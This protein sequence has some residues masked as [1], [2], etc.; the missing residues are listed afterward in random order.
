MPFAPFSTAGKS[1]VS[2]TSDLSDI[3]SGIP[4]AVREALKESAEKMAEGARSRVPVDTGELRDS[5]EVV[6]YNEPG[7]VGY[8]VVAGATADQLRATKWDRKTGTRTYTGGMREG[9]PY[10]HWV[11]Y[12]SVHNVPAHPF[13][14]PQ[15]WEKRDE[16]LDAVSEAL[17][18]V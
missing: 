7:F 8:R 18:N 9:A 13:L 6:P 15:L 10:A 16:T 12:G 14:T 11:E 2:L 5:I 1:G 3:S 4:D 17:E